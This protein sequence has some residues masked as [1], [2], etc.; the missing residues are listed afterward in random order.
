MTQPR[1]LIEPLCQQIWSLKDI[2]T[3]SSNLSEL[4]MREVLREDSDSFN[5]NI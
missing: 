2:E 3:I 5:F 1:C 4:E